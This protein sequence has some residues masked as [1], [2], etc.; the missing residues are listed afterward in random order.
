MRR[1]LHVHALFLAKRGT[2]ILDLCGEPPL[3]VLG[4]ES[5]MMR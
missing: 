5:L 4:S 3:H 1:T 2:K